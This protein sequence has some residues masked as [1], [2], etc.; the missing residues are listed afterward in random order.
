MEKEY[1]LLPCPFCGWPAWLRESGTGWVVKCGDGCEAMT[2]PRKT[3]EEAVAA[4]N[5]RVPISRGCSTCGNY[6]YT[7]DGCQHYC[8]KVHQ[9][10]E[11]HDFCSRWERPR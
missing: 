11:P 6:L 1:N 7:K 10:R 5:Q 3:K 9:K 8:T 4:W 2:W